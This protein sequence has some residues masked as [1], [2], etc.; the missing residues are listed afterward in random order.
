MS[1]YHVDKCSSVGGGALNVLSQTSITTAEW[2]SIMRDAMLAQTLIRNKQ[3]IL[4]AL[5]TRD[6]VQ[7]DAMGKLLKK[8]YDA[9][10]DAGYDQGWSEGYNAGYDNGSR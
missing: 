1:V 8:I 2:R 6:L 10:Y 7:A 9:G 4:E 3:Q 5:N